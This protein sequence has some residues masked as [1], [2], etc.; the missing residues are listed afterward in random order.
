MPELSG[1]VR[2]LVRAVAIYWLVRVI[3]QGKAMLVTYDARHVIP[4]L[5]TEP[6]S[7]GHTFLGVR[8]ANEPAV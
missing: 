8:A 4:L 5:P 6:R 1:V 3:M 2:D 7:D